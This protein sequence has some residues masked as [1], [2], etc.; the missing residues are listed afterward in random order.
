[1]LGRTEQAA[2]R[3]FLRESNL[4]GHHREN[5]KSHARCWYL[6]IHWRENIGLLERANDMRE[7]NV[8]SGAS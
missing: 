8:W 4:H 6:N 7:K 5:F 3:Y 2:N 1:M